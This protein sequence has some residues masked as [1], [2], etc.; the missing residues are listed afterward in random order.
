MNYVVINMIKEIRLLGIKLDH[1]TNFLLYA[2]DFQFMLNKKQSYKICMVPH[3]KDKFQSVTHQNVLF[4][5]TN[6]L[7]EKTN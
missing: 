2:H 6:Y 7:I 3:P 1:T 4:N 5:E